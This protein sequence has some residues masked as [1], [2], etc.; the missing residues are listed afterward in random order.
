MQYSVNIIVASNGGMRIDTVT[1][2]REALTTGSYRPGF[3]YAEGILPAGTY[4]IIASTFKPEQV[5]LSLIARLLL[6]SSHVEGKVTTSSMAVY[7]GKPLKHVRVIRDIYDKS[8]I[9]GLKRFG[10]G[11]RFLFVKNTAIPIIVQYQYRKNE[12]HGDGLS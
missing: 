5:R 11:N 7:R 10:S 3:C 6:P 12:V 4:T 9:E 8:I 1:R 2:D